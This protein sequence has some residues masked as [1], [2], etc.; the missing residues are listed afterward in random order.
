MVAD[1]DDGI[2]ERIVEPFARSGPG[3]ARF[4]ASVLLDLV[5]PLNLVGG[6]H[7]SVHLDAHTTK[8]GPTAQRPLQALAMA[9][10]NQASLEHRMNDAVWHRTPEA[11][12]R[13]FAA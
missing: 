11:E 3:K 2:A 4:G 13:F 5:R 10:A 6:K 12:S 9:G 8:G 1:P 7:Q